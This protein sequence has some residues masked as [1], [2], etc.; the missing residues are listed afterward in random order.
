[1]STREA[2]AIVLAAGKGT[3]LNST[4]PKPLHEIAGRPLLQFSLD[5]CHQAG[6]GPTIL[7]YD[8]DFPEVMR[9]A[10]AKAKAIPQPGHLYGTGHAVQ[11]ALLAQPQHTATAVVLYADTPLLQP[12]TV[13]RLI[14]LRAKSEAA[15]V[16]LSAEVA[17]PNGYGRIIRDA[18]SGQVRAIVE[19]HIASEAE[20]QICEIN[21]G[22]MVFESDWLRHNIAKIRPDPHKGELLL[23]DTVKLALAQGKDV[24]CLQLDNSSEGIGCDSQQDLAK[25][26]RLLRNK[27]LDEL[28]AHGVSIEDPN[29]TYIDLDVAI[30]SDTRILAGCH[31]LGKT[32][33]G[34]QCHIG[35]NAQITDSKISD[36][37][38]VKHASILTST[39]I[40]DGSSVGPFAHLRDG[41]ILDKKVDI[42]TSSEIKN[43]KVG[44][45]TVMRHFGFLGDA[46]VGE[47][48][49]IGAGVV[50]CNYDGT[51]K[52]RTTIG[53]DSFIGSGSMLVAP[54]A[55]G[56]NVY[57]GAGSVVTRNVA[58]GNV[59]YGVPARSRA[60][61][62]KDT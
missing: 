60:T 2:M 52:H 30:G 48:V 41:T 11:T 9:S 42:G 17:N 62:N 53:D 14:S 18:S 54:L 36:R 26:E 29:R 37:C 25:A 49:N 23:T 47:N 7:V 24:E 22:I 3:R 21:T 56:D 32:I 1:M 55:I 33:I 4:V 45:G 38:T 44:T 16:V 58:D 8:A 5:L 40:A 6:L 20:R 51:T 10:G 46:D 13:T 19:S 39:E 34:E 59:V 50:T 12:D 15:I 35:P 43:S 57:V 61:A 27:K 31:I 28:M